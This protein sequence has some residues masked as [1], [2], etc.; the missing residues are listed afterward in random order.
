MGLFR[1]RDRRPDPPA[2]TPD[3]ADAPAPPELDLRALHVD[4][5]ALIWLGRTSIGDD[6]WAF[7][8]P[9]KRMGDHWRAMRAAHVRTGLWP[10][11]MT[12][13][14]DICAALP[15]AAMPQY[16]VAAELDAAT[17]LDPTDAI[18]S[19]D[20]W[21]SDQN[22]EFAFDDRVPDVLAP[23]GE[24]ITV[25]AAD[26]WTVL[27]PSRDPTEV[28][29]RLG[30]SGGCNYDVS[31]HIHTAVLRGW[32][33][34]YAAEVVALDDSQTMELLVARPPTTP[35]ECHAVALQQFR[36]CEDLVTQGGGSIHDLAAQQVPSPSWYF[37]WD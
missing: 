13:V 37:W 9:A 18:A 10:V 11:S 27:V 31:P 32:A 36:Y 3:R 20:G 33:D 26:G 25:W 1:R 17:K 6:V 24:A 35:E 23:H 30:W 12:E 5:D 34:R 21:D 14:G 7:A 4:P 22:E 15:M 8:S 2:G 19:L 28:P 29:V 16:D